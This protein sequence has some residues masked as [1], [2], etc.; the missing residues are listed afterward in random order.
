MTVK[1]VVRG[2][3][4][5]L[6]LP[7]GLPDGQEVEIIIRPDPNI[8]DQSGVSPMDRLRRA[9]GGWD[10]DGQTLDDIFKQIRR[11]RD[12]PSRPTG[13]EE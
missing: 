3:S 11:D 1:G 8:P 13:L 2:Q 9:F 5:S 10:D 6:H 12:L 4:I 7:T